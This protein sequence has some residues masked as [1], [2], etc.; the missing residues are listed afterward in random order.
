MAIVTETQKI[1]AASKT[2]DSHPFCGPSSNM[3]LI[4]KRIQILAQVCNYIVLL[5]PCVKRSKTHHHIS[6]YFIMITTSTCQL[7]IG[8]AQ[9]V[10]AEF[11]ELEIEVVVNMALPTTV[12]GSKAAIHKKI[13]S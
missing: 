1:L 6:K 7:R 4:V 5:R 3:A 8:N 12:V 13:S 11:C 9:T 2:P 10:L